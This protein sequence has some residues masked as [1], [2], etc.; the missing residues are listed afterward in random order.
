MFFK[1][2]SSESD[3][4]WSAPDES[5]GFQDDLL[6][7]HTDSDTNTE[8]TD[9]KSLDRGVDTQ[10]CPVWMED[11]ESEV[12]MQCDKPFTTTNRRTHWY[13]LNIIVLFILIILII[14]NIYY[15]KN[16]NE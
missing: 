16:N 7:T 15:Y 2:C 1:C 4:V 9:Y 5:S 13:F 11:N 14:L 12:C 6:E 8:T 10:L 3:T